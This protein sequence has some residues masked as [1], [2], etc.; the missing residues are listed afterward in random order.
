MTFK[1]LILNVLISF[2]VILTFFGLLLFAATSNNPYWNSI[3][4]SL[5]IIFYIGLTA[6]IIW[7]DRKE[8]KEYQNLCYNNQKIT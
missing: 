3:I 5:M 2:V 6:F 1:N 4:L 7:K 8:E